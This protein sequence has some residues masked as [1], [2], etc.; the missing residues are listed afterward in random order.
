MT[1]REYIY[2]W[3]IGVQPVPSTV[4]GTLRDIERETNEFHHE[5]IREEFGSTPEY[6]QAVIDDL[7]ERAKRTMW[8]TVGSDRKP[9][10]P[11]H[12]TTPEERIEKRAEARYEAQVR[13][14][15]RLHPGPAERP[16]EGYE[17]ACPL[18]AQLRV[19]T[20][21]FAGEV[22]AHCYMKLARSAEFDRENLSIDLID[23][24]NHGDG[25]GN[26]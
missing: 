16:C 23:A 13:K 2:P 4:S 26:D 22:C 7:T 12:I 25:D 6:M 11:M 18:P 19:S 1:E 10:R 14:F 21:E 17:R 8:L 15:D 5:R 9:I 20:G 3:D 24:D